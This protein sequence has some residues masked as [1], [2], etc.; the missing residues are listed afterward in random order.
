MSDS[1]GSDQF[2]ESPIIDP[3]PPTPIV[4]Y[5]P[6]VSPAPEANPPSP[7]IHLQDDVNTN[8]PN[9]HVRHS[10]Y[11]LRIQVPA[12][13]GNE[14]HGGVTE[15]ELQTEPLAWLLLY[16]II[17]IEPDPENLTA[18]HC[19]TSTNINSKESQSTLS[20]RLKNIDAK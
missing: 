16:S 1:E 3:V 13:V 2:E 11:P 5:P 4:D 18:S 19:L 7:N 14:N 17:S 9:N 15:N 6:S 20:L 12:L 10:K 8:A